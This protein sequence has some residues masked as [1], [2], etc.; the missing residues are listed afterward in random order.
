MFLYNIR[1]KRKK[2]PPRTT[3][4]LPLWQEVTAGEATQ[5]SRGVS[6]FFFLHFLAG[7][8]DFVVGHRLKEFILKDGLLFLFLTSSFYFQ[9]LKRLAES[10][11]G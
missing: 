4:N 9:V 5:G 2:I 7:R 8:K 10:E 3:D 11:F 6:L 1:K